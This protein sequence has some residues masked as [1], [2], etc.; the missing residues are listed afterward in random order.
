LN[1]ATFLKTV[2]TGYWT[3]TCSVPGSFFYGLSKDAGN[4]FSVLD[5]WFFFRIWNLKQE[6]D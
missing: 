3:W 2:W 6:V 4:G 5:F 1:P